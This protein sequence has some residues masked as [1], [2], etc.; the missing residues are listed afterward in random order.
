M[1]IYIYIYIY[2]YTYIYTYI[3]IYGTES[4]MPHF[5][6]RE[7]FPSFW[8]HAVQS[9]PRFLQLIDALCNVVIGGLGRQLSGST[10]GLPHN[11][12]LCSGLGQV[13]SKYC[14]SASLAAGPWLQ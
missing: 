12:L 9:I 6:G 14:L 8:T 5:S 3:Y 1:H 11:I 13:L 10:A 2:I 4:N 7:M